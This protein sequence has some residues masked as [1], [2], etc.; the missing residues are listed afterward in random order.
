MERIFRTKPWQL[1]RQPKRILIMR[2]QAIGDIM[3]TFPYIQAL[4][5]K[6]PHAQIDFVTKN[7]KVE[8]AQKMGIFDKVY[9]Q[10]DSQRLIP[11][12]LDAFLLILKLFFKRYDVII[13][14]QN[15]IISRPI[16]KF[17]FPKAFAE[18]DVWGDEMGSIRYYQTF[19]RCG[20]LDRYEQASLPL[21]NTAFA[22]KM[23]TENGW[24]GHSKIIVL[25]P[26]GAFPSRHWPV[27]NYVTFA[28]IWL[29]KYPNTQFVTI[30]TNK[31]RP[32]SDFFKQQLG[33]KLINL[34]EKTTL[35]EA[36]C[37]VQRASLMISEDSGL[38]HIGWVLKIPTVALIGSTHKNR[39]AQKGENM[40]ILNSDDMPCGNCMKADCPFDKIPPCLSRYTP[41]MIVNM[42]EKLA[43]AY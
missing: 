28:K 12:V 39:S 41:A 34:T 21:A 33:R 8:I 7:E 4:K 25:N 3:G 22:D 36:F 37:L 40:R 24:N 17:L 2:F 14:L 13:D 43:L 6:F 15:H 9:P 38:L 18:F 42:A 19:E 1:K 29:E 30:G 5:N 16:R 31:I 27:E 35:W 23:L 11:Q 10:T 32:Q 26:A 20:L